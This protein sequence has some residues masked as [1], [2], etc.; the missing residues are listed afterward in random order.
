MDTTALKAF[1]QKAR[2]DLMHQVGAQLKVVLA[3]DSLARREQPQAILKLE[4]EIE[5]KG[6]DV[7]I[8]EVAYT[9][10]NRFCALRFMD[11][12]HYNKVRSEEHTSEL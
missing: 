3:L 7:V 5:K 8:D 10:F 12:N 4:S 2:T 1:A 9:W 6:K 11:V